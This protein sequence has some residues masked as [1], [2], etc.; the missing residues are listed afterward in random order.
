LR[1]NGCHQE[2]GNGVVGRGGGALWKNQAISFINIMT[3]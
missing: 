1:P 2:K 3:S